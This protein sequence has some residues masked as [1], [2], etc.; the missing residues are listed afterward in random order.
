MSTS[1]TPV[2]QPGETRRPPWIRHLLLSV[3]VAVIVALGRWTWLLIRESREAAIS[4]RAQS[5]LNQLQ[6]ALHLYHDRHGCF[7]PAYV[8]NDEG[9]PVHSWRVLILPFIEQQALYDAYR[10]A[11][12]WNGPNNR[13]LADRMPQIFHMPKDPA[14]TSMT[15]IVAIVGPGTAF[16]GSS[17]TRI[18]DFT[19]GL[20]NT[21]LL[22]EI[23]SSNICWM[24]PTDLVIDEMAFT[25]NDRQRLS[26]SSLRRR[27]PHAVFADSIHAY[28]ISPRLRPETLKA[29][30]TIAG[31][32]KMFMGEIDR[33][34]LVS[35]DAGSAADEKIR[36]LSLDGLKS[37]WLSR[38][39]ITDVALHRLATAP[40]LAKLHLRS[41]RITD[42]GLRQF[43]PG[44]PPQF[45]GLCCTEVSDSG[46]QYLAEL[47]ELRFPGFTIDVRGSR[48][49]IAGVAQFLKSIPEP[50]FTQDVRD[51]RV[52][53]DEGSVSHDV[54]HL[55][56]SS[57]T[58][59]Q[60]ECF[61]GLRTFYQ[62]D[63]SQTRITDSGLKIVADFV[64]LVHLSVSG[65]EITDAGL[66][67]LGGLTQL[68][69]ID[70]RNT[71]VTDEGVARIEQTLPNCRIKRTPR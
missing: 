35:F 61:R 24:E 62:I 8:T 52:H 48:V 30:T 41:T 71:N 23:T 67:H 38:S 17:C 26:I 51:V 50:E 43:L 47:K 4:M 3:A 33:V 66:V 39:E 31:G 40:S 28:Q 56:G 15:N 27:G 29:L 21:I 49:T 9:T 6:L 7:P 36:T 63:L 37:L 11:E 25:V 1:E 64:N 14:A 16:P 55:G 65:T 69:S 34:G 20:D 58:D 22:T 19:D 42:D 2:A 68:Q 18:E 12:P 57:I 32:E 60:L 70:L 54:M 53:F 10:F 5:H 44:P 13:K 46:L 45:L 59:A